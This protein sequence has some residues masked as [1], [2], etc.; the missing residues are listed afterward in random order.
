MTQM[1][2]DFDIITCYNAILMLAQRWETSLR[3]NSVF[4]RGVPDKS[5]RQITV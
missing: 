5:I 1:N 2:D 3:M 4:Y